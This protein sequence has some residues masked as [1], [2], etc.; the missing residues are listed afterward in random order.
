MSVKS[1]PDALTTITAHM[2]IVSNTMSATHIPGMERALTQKAASDVV[3]QQVTTS[4][5]TPEIV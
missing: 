2:L 5:D 4:Q 3:V 1:T